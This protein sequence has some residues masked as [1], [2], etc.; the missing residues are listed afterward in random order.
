MYSYPNYYNPNNKNTANYDNYFSSIGKFFASLNGSGIGH[1]DR[2]PF[3]YKGN[4]FTRGVS[5]KSCGT[6][7]FGSSYG[8]GG[9]HGGYDYPTNLITTEVL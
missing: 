7:Y 4:K 3:G 9:G 6:G 8:G 2:H 1:S 5:D